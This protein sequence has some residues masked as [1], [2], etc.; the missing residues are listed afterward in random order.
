KYPI[1]STQNHWSMESR[2]T[3]VRTADLPAYTKLGDE[4]VKKKDSY[5]ESWKINFGERLGELDHTPPNISIYE[6]PFNESQA[7]AANESWYSER[8]QW[9]MSIDQST[10]IGCG[11]CTIACQSEN[12][13]PAVG[14]TEV[15]KGR[16]MTWIRVDRYFTG[17]PMNPG[18]LYHQPVACVHCENAPCETVCPV[19]AT[20]HGPTGLNYMVYNRCIGT[21]YCANNCPYK[22][23]RFNFF[24]YGVKRLNGGLREEIPEGT[25]TPNNINLIPPRLREK[26]AEIQKMKMNPDVTVRS[27]GVMEKCTYCIQRINAARYEAKLQDLE[28]IPD[29][30]FHTACQAACPT[31]AIVFGDLLDETSKIAKAAKEGRTYALLGY[32]NTRPRTTYQVALANPNPKLREPVEDPFHHGDTHDA[33]DHDGDYGTGGE[34]APPSFLDPFKKQSDDGYA[35]SLRVLGAA[36]G[37]N[38]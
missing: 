5:G 36:T 16:E 26:L 32:L 33:Y 27:R 21:R 7:D 8:P 1:S 22:V 13:I 18:E 37:V 17:D 31:G 30:F 38:A 11:T 12:N 24:D 19:N 28:Q 34:T 23:R 3:I 6:N 29:G 2:T 10:C 35:V 15:R 9:G 25:P 4:K 14:K 20:V